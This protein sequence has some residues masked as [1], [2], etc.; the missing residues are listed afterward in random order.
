MGRDHLK[1]TI[2]EILD[3]LSAMRK[4][5]MGIWVRVGWGGNGVERMTF[6]RVVGERLSEEVTFGQDLNDAKKENRSGCM[7]AE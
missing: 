2:L 5:I 1:K 7:Q 4:K 3:K 6:P